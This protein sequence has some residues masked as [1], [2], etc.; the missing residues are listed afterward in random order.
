MYIYGASGHGRVII[1]I[2]D[3]YEKIHGVFDDDQDKKEV[4]GYPVM[5]PIPADYVF[6]SDVFIAIGDNK[7]R[8]MLADR[9]AGRVK[10]ASIIHDSVIFSKRANIGDGCVV[11]EGAIVKVGTSIGHQTIINSGA[12]VD[13]DC[14]IGDF[15]HIAPQATLCGGI[16]VGEGTLIGANSVILPGVKIGKWC[17]IG[18]HSVV[19]KDIP[20]FSLWRGAGIVAQVSVL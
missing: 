19:N 4:L 1:D 14:I 3:S 13:H 20:D 9:L 17:T 8:K 11:M 6:Q 5:G 12:S 7:I 16:T 18:A 2:I 10:F 15:V